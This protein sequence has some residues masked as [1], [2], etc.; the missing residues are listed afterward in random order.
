MDFDEYRNYLKLNVKVPEKQ[1][2]YYLGWVT[3]FFASC[4]KHPGQRFDPKEVSEF[5]EE[6]SQRCEDW[7]V[8]QAKK[9]IELFRYLQNREND[10]RQKNNNVLSSEDW[11]KA[12]DTL[13]KRLRLKQRS[14]SVGGVGIVGAPFR[15][16]PF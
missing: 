10:Y 2:S 11:K 5:I 12:A 6:L 7:Q 15:S 8:D 9:S 13:V 16:S 4:N 14:Y 3:Q 1:I